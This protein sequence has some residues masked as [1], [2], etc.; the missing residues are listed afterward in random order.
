MQEMRRKQSLSRHLQQNPNLTN[1]TNIPREKR[2]ELREVLQVRME[3]DEE[4]PP[5]NEL[6]RPL[7]KRP[8]LQYSQV[9]RGVEARVEPH[10]ASMDSQARLSQDHQAKSWKYKT[11]VNCHEL[12]T[13]ERASESAR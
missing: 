5:A 8:S 10:I 13:D 4:M 2:D 7:S 9:V 3:E 12:P 6:V 11:E 1:N